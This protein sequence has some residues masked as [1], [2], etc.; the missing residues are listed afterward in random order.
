MIKK[1]TLD[2][3]DDLQKICCETFVETF[4]NENSKEDMEKFLEESYNKNVLIN[5]LNNNESETYLVYKDGKVAGYLKI[6]KGEAQTESGYENSL[7]IQR[8]YILKEFKGKHIGSDLMELAEKR[9]R[10]WNLKYIWL[11]VWEHNYS[12]LEFYKSKGYEKFSE[13]VFVLGEDRQTDYLMKKY[14][15]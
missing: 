9:A 14:V 2:E 4:E 15:N 7:E 10:E 12:A 5:E 1:C 8:I 6:N 11:G 3:L 13:H